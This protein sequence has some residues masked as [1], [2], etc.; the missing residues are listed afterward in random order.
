MGSIAAALKAGHKPNTIPTATEK[1]NAK[2]KELK[3]MT[4]FHPAKTVIN[5]ETPTP[6]TIPVNPPRSVITIDSTRNSHQGR[7]RMS[8]Q[9]G[10]INEA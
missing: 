8:K 9:A 2:N 5:Q 1:K 6:K 7:S 4:V 10:A 3:L